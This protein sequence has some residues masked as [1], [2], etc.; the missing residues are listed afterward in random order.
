MVLAELGCHVRAAEGH[1]LFQEVL[2]LHVE[3]EVQVV[4]PFLQEQ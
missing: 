4:L 1:C 2:V 3:P